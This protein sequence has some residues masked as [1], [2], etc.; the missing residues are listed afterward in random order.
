MHSLLAKIP[1][2]VCE[3]VHRERVA[4]MALRHFSFP[5]DK[6]TLRQSK[7]IFKIL[8][9]QVS[10]NKGPIMCSWLIYHTTAPLLTL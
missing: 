10:H 5:A 1:A 9:S 6:Q 3:E 8:D 7:L 2:G 4:W